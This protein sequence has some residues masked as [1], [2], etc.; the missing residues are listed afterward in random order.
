MN[1]IFEMNPKE[2][3]KITSAILPFKNFENFCEQKDCMACVINE[4]SDS[5]KGCKKIFSEFQKE[6]TVVIANKMD[7]IIEKLDTIIE[8]F[9]KKE[10][11]W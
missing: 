3:K 1:D 6:D 5:I 7:T 10:E 8:L 4:H 2:R 11:L 9:S